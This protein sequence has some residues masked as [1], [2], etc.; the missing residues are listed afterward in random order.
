MSHTRTRRSVGQPSREP[1][2]WARLYGSRLSWPVTLLVLR[3]PLSANAVSVISIAV[4]AA[5]GACF[6]ASSPGWNIAAVALILLSWILD[7]VDG[8]VAR[9]RG[10]ASLDGEFI[11]AS[12]HQIVPPA[13]FAGL[14]LGAHVRHPDLLWVLALGFSSA[15][16]STRFVGG[17]I[18]QLV[19][20]GVR[21]GLAA[22]TKLGPGPAEMSAPKG[23]CRVV[24]FA[25][26]FTPLFVDFNILHV[27]IAVVI[28]DTAGVRAGRWTPLDILHIAYGAAFPI[29]KLGSMAVAWRRGVSGR[30]REVLRK[31]EDAPAKRGTPTK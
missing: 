13:I 16:L 14:A 6:V 26:L 30:V 27:L 8:E 29:A 22:G 28:A 1:F 23:R 17:M 31:Q 4:G 15:V 3:T 5:G 21:R 18:D 19:L 2:F 10:T 7:C 25:R 24:G 12:R 20:V 11:D 9:V